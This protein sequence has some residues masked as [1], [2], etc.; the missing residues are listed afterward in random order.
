MT[1]RLWHLS[2]NCVIN[3]CLIFVCSP[4]ICLVT[5]H[6]IFFSPWIFLTSRMSINIICF[7]QHLFVFFLTIGLFRTFSPLNINEHK[8]SIIYFVIFSY[9]LTYIYLHLGNVC[10]V[11]D[12]KDV[13]YFKFIPLLRGI[14]LFPVVSYFTLYAVNIVSL[15][16]L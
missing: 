8:S 1:F 7:M 10:I 12:F 15:K 16:C 2:F 3:I 6:R 13:T 5:A 11:L 14:K 9:P 4:L